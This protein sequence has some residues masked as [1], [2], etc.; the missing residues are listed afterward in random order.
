V[1]ADR[2]DQLG[3]MAGALLNLYVGDKLG[4]IKTLYVYVVNIHYVHMLIYQ[5]WYWNRRRYH[6]PSSFDQLRHDD[7]CQNLQR[8][9]Q[10]DA[11]IHRADLS[12]GVF[13]ARKTRT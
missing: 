9:L 6:S 10:R 3:C 5:R 11:H 12:I 2:P 13:E 7:L 1:L 8:Y 4:R